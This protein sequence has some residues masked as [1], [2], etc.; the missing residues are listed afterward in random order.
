MNNGTNHEQQL[1][2]STFMNGVA[3]R[4]L[5]R[6]S[7]ATSAEYSLADMF[8]QFMLE[9]TSVR[10]TLDALT[11][12]HLAILARQTFRAEYNTP[13]LRGELGKR[14]KLRIAARLGESE[15]DGTKGA[16]VWNT[17]TDWGCPRKHC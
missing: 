5:A 13:W 2:P 11:E 9:P 14:L 17:R 10:D 15:M 4:T 3:K 6:A 16:S 8:R 7:D 1:P 12:E